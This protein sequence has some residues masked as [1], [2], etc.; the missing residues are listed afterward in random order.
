MSDVLRR[1]LRR[2]GRGRGGDSGE[3]V[4]RLERQ[5]R[6]ARLEL[7]A[8][9]RSI[10]RLTAEVGRVRGAAG[11]DA[12]QRGQADVER[13]VAAIGA[14]LVQLTTQAH[15]YRTGAREIGVGDVLDVG[16]RL[17]R[18]LREVGVDTVGEVGA[19]EP[20]DPDRHDPLSTAA[21]PAAGERVVV[22]MV[23]LSYQDKVVRRAGVEPAGGGGR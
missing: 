8:R 9:D 19:A 11:E 15:L 10:E 18:S 12:R 21:A 3:R 22:R 1:L 6:E 2:V 4:L 17:V 23:G 14:P 16:M 13:L 7:A 5:L 20:Y